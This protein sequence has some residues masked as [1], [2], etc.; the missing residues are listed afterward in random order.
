[1]MSG[2]KKKILLVDDH[3]MARKALKLYLEH[4]GYDCEEVDHGAAALK[5]LATHS[6][7]HLVISDNRMPVMTGMEFLQ[8]LKRQPLLQTLPVILYSGNLVPEVSEQA[9]QLGA[10]AVLDKPYD[11]ADLAALVSRA[12]ESY[13][14]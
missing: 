3:E 11:F 8:Q 5:F 4:Q 1:M 9:W 14:S 7:V 13:Q 10:F 12:L 2:Q 6:D